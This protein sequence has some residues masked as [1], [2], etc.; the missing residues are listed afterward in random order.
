MGYGERLKRKKGVILAL[1]LGMAVWGCIPVMA[2][3]R[4]AVT[5]EAYWDENQVGI[6]RWKKVDR[7]EEY[8]V[9]LYEGDDQF[10]TSFSVRGLKA[11][12]REYMKDGYTYRFSVC[13]VPKSGQKAY[14]SGDWKDSDI[15][16]AEGIGENSGKWRT[17][18][19][20]KKYERGDKSFITN[21]WEMIQ[22][23][24]YYFNPDGFV[25]TGWQQIDSKWYYL[26]KDGVMQT[27][28]LDYE[29]NWY[30]LDSNGAR[31]TGWKEVKPGEWYYLDGEGKMLANTMIDGY[32]LDD[33]GK[34]VRQ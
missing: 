19:Q 18:T 12:F 33:S 17:Y 30:Y 21:Q 6:G 7:A 9:R 11:D 27:G 2:A 5:D 3:V 23:K 29:G 28:W 22:S 24:W 16:E 32:W 1:L 15:L 4:L 26:D 20:G 25:Q 31:V 8:R 14:I 34:W 10:I 13:A